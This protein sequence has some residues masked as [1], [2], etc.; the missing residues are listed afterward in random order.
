MKISAHVRQAA[1][2]FRKCAGAKN[3]VP[4]MALGGMTSSSDRMKGQ[5]VCDILAI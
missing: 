4:T 1:V 5:N 2:V 3:H